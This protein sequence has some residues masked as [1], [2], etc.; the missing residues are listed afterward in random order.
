MFNAGVPRHVFYVRVVIRPYGL[1]FLQMY[2]SRYISFVTNISLEC[3]RYIRS[4]SSHAK[5]WMLRSY[6][7][8]NA[9]DNM[10]SWIIEKKKKKRKK[11]WAICVHACWAGILKQRDNT[12]SSNWF[13]LVDSLQ[14]SYNAACSLFFLKTVTLYAKPIRWIEKPAALV[15][16]LHLWQSFIPLVGHVP[17]DISISLRKI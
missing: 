13:A 16:Y 8:P 12:L 17:N 2:V 11:K 1:Q 14:T 4:Y 3:T 15:A 6:E 9:V 7:F 5:W 10:K